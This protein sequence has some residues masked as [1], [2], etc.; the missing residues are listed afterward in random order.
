MVFRVD[1]E[2]DAIEKNG[3]K[4]KILVLG[5]VMIDEYHYCRLERK[6]PEGPFLVWDLQRIEKKL[7]GAGNLAH[8]IKALGAEVVLAGIAFDGELD[9]L[10]LENKIPVVVERDGRP[11]T[12]KRRFFD[13]ETNALLGR[14][15]IED[16]TPIT[17]T[18]SGF[19]AK[20]LKDDF[21]L[22]VFSDYNKGMFNPDTV[23]DFLRIKAKKRMADVKP[24][25]AKL[26]KGKVDVIKMNFKE[27]RELSKAY[28]ED[29]KNTDADIER[30][31]K[32]VR[33]DLKADLLVTRSEK[34]MSYIGDVT[35]HSLV[36]SKEVVDII[37]AGDTVTA[38]FSVAL[39]CKV[40]IPG[41]LRISNMAAAVKVTKRGAVPVSLEEIK[42]RLS[43][44]ERKILD[45]DSLAKAI[46][47]QRA[48]GKKVVFTNGC[49]DVLHHGHLYFLKKARELGDILVVALNSDA[50]VK[51]LKGPGR[52]KIPQH[53]RAEMLAAFPF[54]D[55]VVV[56]D[57]DTPEYLVEM[58]KPDIYVKGK[59][60]TVG[61]LP[62]ARI[63]E[64]YGG[65]VELI[66][67]V[68]EGGKKVSSRDLIG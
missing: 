26:F 55:Y 64:N 57:T 1:C 43:M 49:F 21:D 13:A 67:L 16:R 18:T 30:A 68:N 11:T 33:E 48:I 25:N 19:L 45:E 63:V 17:K 7:G 39:A 34:G 24:G 14:E 3:G 40:P 41:A 47:R 31:G 37:G 23:P 61:T 12:L 50:S 44:E 42:K 27:F 20:R 52:P 59:D 54:V 29:V 15:D 53:G 4:L 51:K 58:L 22:V 35:S 2:I 32:K 65:R 38:A 9:R 6:T 60:Y 8:N 56:F 66:D 28:G 62:E 46:D 10:A 5:D 36:E